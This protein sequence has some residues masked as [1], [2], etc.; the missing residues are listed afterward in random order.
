MCAVAWCIGSIG[1]ISLSS[2]TCI[3]ARLGAVCSSG[4]ATSGAPACALLTYSAAT[5]W[6]TARLLIAT[7]CACV[8]CMMRATTNSFPLNLPHATEAHQRHSRRWRR[9]SFVDLIEQRPAVYKACVASERHEARGSWWSLGTFCASVRVGARGHLPAKWVW[10]SMMPEL[11]P[12]T[13]GF[14]GLQK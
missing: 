12:T 14:H 6:S 10:V 5:S 13:L 7:S 11:C 8:R 2:T 4:P 1:R 3:A 9:A